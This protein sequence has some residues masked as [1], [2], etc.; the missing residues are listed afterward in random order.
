MPEPA[1][2]DLGPLGRR[3]TV[4]GP[5]QEKA[6]AQT[7]RATVP[8]WS[9]PALLGPALL[10]PVPGEWPV[11]A[12]L[13]PALLGPVPALLGPVPGECRQQ[14]GNECPESSVPRNLALCSSSPGPL[15]L[16]DGSG[17][18]TRSR[19]AHQQNNNPCQLAWIPAPNPRQMPKASVLG[20]DL[21]RQTQFT[22]CGANTFWPSRQVALRHGASQRAGLCRG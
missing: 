7:P 17:R 12:L 18:T 15:Y 4:A 20:Q 13:G 22:R 10:G 11:P 3:D 19:R 16:L 6:Q 8:A 14:G 9:R 2:F 1:R 5:P 21:R